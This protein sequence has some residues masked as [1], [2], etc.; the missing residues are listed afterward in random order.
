MVQRR[1]TSIIIAILVLV[2]F[3]IRWGMDDYMCNPATWHSTTQKD[4]KG[5][6]IAWRAAPHEGREFFGAVFSGGSGSPAVFAMLG[7]QRSM[8]GN[9]LWDYSDVLFHKGKPYEMIP[10]LES[11]VTLNPG[12]TE[13]WSLYAWH[14]GWNLY[15]YTNDQTMRA[16][17]IREAEAIYKRAIAANPDKPAPSM[18][19]AWFYTQRRGDYETARKYLEPVLYGKNEDGTPLYRM[20]TINDVNKPDWEKEQLWEPDNYGRRLAMIYL[21]LGVLDLRPTGD[22]VMLQKALDTYKLINA[23][24]PADKPDAAATRLI[25]ELTDGMADPIWVSKQRELELEHQRVFG[26]DQVQANPIEKHDAPATP[27]E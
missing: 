1:T 15:I 25:K 24:L 21:K 13:A 12:F 7:G 6:W 26:F 18:D 10:V 4:K 9:I 5:N 23:S 11:C 20:M 17:R 16:K 22:Q 14:L 27:A 8:V 3:G 2:V 19:I